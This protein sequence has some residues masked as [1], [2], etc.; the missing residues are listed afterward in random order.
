M[1]KLKSETKVTD[2]AYQPFR[3]QNQYAHRETE[4][5]Y[6]FFRYC[7]PDAGRFV[8][9]DPIGLW[10]GENLYWFASNITSWIDP[11]GLE[12][13]LGFLT[14]VSAKQN[15]GAVSFLNVNGR[16]YK[17]VSGKVPK[18]LHPKL[19]KALNEIESSVPNIPGW[20]GKCAEV[21]AINKALKKGEKLDGATIE[22]LNL[23]KDIRFWKSK[24]ACATCNPLLA[25]FQ[26]TATGG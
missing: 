23:A 8:N 13:I 2:S 10:G 4:F 12:S 22:T 24:L 14:K 16:I 17:G 18:K 26:I 7:D 15:T 19:K 20:H 9:Q 21:A 5:H 1:G 11:L 6:N 3:L 25:M